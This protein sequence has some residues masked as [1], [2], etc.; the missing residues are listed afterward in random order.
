MSLWILIALL[1]VPM[2]AGSLLHAAAF[3]LVVAAV[4]NIFSALRR[5]IAPGFPGKP[6]RRHA[7][8]ALPA[9]AVLAA[10]GVLYMLTTGVVPV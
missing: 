1:A 6:L 5:G 10:D 9:L 3:M 7:K 4:V 8:L 2:A